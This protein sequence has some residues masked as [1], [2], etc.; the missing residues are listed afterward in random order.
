M[1]S[2]ISLPLALAL[3]HPDDSSH[4]VELPDGKI[5]G[6]THGGVSGDDEETLRQHQTR[7]TI[8]T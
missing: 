4:R 1:R 3:A 7:Q 8:T 6:S 2:F 5:I